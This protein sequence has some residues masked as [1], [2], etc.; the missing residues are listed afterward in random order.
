MSNYRRM[1]IKRVEIAHLELKYS[2][3][4]IQDF[5]SVHRLAYSIEK[6]GQTTPIVV[7]PGALPSYIL[8]DG[9]LRVAALKRCGKDTVRAEIW[10][11]E[12]SSLLAYI[13]TRVQGRKWDVFEQASLIRELHYS[14]ALSQAKTASLLGKDASWVSRRL[15]L[16]DN[17]DEKSVDLIRQG[18]LSTWSATR[19]LIPMARANPLHANTLIENILKE[20]ISTRNLALLFKQYRRSGKKKREELVKHPQLFFKVLEMEKKKQE[21]NI[22]KAGPEGKWLKD[23]KVV[24]GILNRQAVTEL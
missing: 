19:V 12:E 22:L 10:E 20:N 23:I 8:I 21:A 11:S 6:F 5:E 2:H 15:S 1:L 9:Y 3:T 17:I 4:R 13:L 16:L 14:K 24:R 7:I 18:H